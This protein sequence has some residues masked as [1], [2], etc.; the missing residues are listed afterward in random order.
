MRRFWR[1]IL[2]F[3]SR[4][5]LRVHFKTVTWELM[6]TDVMISEYS[7]SIIRKYLEVY[8]TPLMYLKDN[9]P[10]NIEGGEYVEVTNDEWEVVEKDSEW[11]IQEI[12]W[13]LDFGA[14]ADFFTDDEEDIIR[15]RNGMKL[16][17]HLLPRLWY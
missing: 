14:E 3:V 6:N 1:Q 10:E 7:A 8:P 11:A 13:A 17:A 4:T 15:Y 2:D 5:A 9:Y 16:F 12:L